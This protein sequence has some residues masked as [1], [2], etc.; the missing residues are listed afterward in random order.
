MYVF[1][2]F[3]AEC[4]CGKSDE[5]EKYKKLSESLQKDKDALLSWTAQLESQNAK[6]Q[7]SLTSKLLPTPEIPFKVEE[8]FLDCETLVRMSHEAGSKDYL[9]IKFAMMK[10]FPE[11]LVGRS[12]TGR[13]SNNPSGRPK[14]KDAPGP[15]ATPQSTNEKSGTG[16]AKIPLDPVKVKW[17]KSMMQ[18]FYVCVVIINFILH[19]QDAF[20]IAA[21][22]LVMT[23]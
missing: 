11:G 12:V 16:T 2:S 4:S 5:V 18:K 1:Y 8:G 21:Y 6:L 19:L 17:I 3:T 9:F 13:V 10:L 14:K 7:D 23:M 20:M 22:L 15:D